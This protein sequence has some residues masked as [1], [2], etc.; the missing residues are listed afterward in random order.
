MVDVATIATKAKIIFFIIVTFLIVIIFIFWCK[1]IAFLST[2]QRIPNVTIIIHFNILVLSCKVI[3][4]Y[5]ADIAN[6]SLD[7]V[8]GSKLSSSPFRQTI[9]LVDILTP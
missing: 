3:I 1:D 2:R 6:H 5:K 8:N 9:K 7:S 4:A